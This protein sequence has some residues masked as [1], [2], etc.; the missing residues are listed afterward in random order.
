MPITAAIMP[1]PEIIFKM[2]SIIPR[3][4]LPFY[5]LSLFDSS[6][7]KV[8]NLGYAAFFSSGFRLL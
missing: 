2:I 6:E 1:I 8:S 4:F 3:F 5:I 7:Y